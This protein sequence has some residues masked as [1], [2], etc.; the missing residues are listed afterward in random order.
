MA[1]GAES[2]QLALPGGAKLTPQLLLLRT[3]LLP[4]NGAI[5]AWQQWRSQVNIEIENVDAGS[6]RL[7]PLV[8]RNLKKLNV[9]DPLLGR[10]KGIYRQTWYQ[11]QVQLHEAAAVVRLFQAAGIDAMLLKGAPLTLRY[12]QD[13]GVRPMTDV[14]V[15]VPTAQRDA[16]INCLSQAGW[17]SHWRPT[18]K[19]TEDYLRI[20][21]S[22]N[23]T[24][25]NGGE[26]DLHWHA[27][28]ECLGTQADSDFWAWAQPLE[29]FGV[30]AKILCPT[31]QLLHTCVH[32]MAFNKTP[33]VHW[34]ADALTI[35]RVAQP[36]VDWE[37]LVN[38]AQQLRL[39]LIL[40]A[41]LG[42]LRLLLDAPVPAETLSQLAALPVSRLERLE[43]QTRVNWFRYMPITWIHYLRYQQQR[44]SP[45]SWPR[46]LAGFPRYVQLYFGFDDL[47]QTLTWAVSRGAARF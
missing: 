25:P 46:L 9:N 27:F 33:T 1:I 17:Q 43:Y 12:Y 13:E 29:F 26:I 8:Y 18:S 28:I 14:D 19:L 41:A 38:Q 32:G 4:D 44:Q 5:S 6:F 10:L 40:S 30:G 7:L 47:K 42:Y 15:L 2:D 35:I 24:H 37:R 21:H 22:W 23:F 34:L 39:S 16:A 45:P 11:N 20:K 3:A 36:A 31:D